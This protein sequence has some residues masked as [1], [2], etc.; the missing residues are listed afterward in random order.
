VPRLTRMELE[1]LESGNYI[2]NRSRAPSYTSEAQDEALPGYTPSPATQV[3]TC[4]QTPIIPPESNH[5]VL[6]LF[7][8]IC[9]FIVLVFGVTVAVVVIVV[10]CLLLIPPHSFSS[11]TF[12]LLTILVRNHHPRPRTH[13]SQF[14]RPQRNPRH[15]LIC[16]VYLHQ[17]KAV[18]TGTF[19]AR[20]C[21][22]GLNMC[23]CHPQNQREGGS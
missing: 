8:R 6:G 12:I 13:Q 14:S 10:V 16:L 9:C 17:R 2:R 19:V 21:S 23:I 5:L 1:A 3:N 20:T 4:T 15:Y 18:W 22:S 7:P 11:I